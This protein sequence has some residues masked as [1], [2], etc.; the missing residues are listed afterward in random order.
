MPHDQN[1]ESGWREDKLQ[2]STVLEQLKVDKLNVLP[3]LHWF[4]N[5][6]KIQVIYS[7]TEILRWPWIKYFCKWEKALWRWQSKVAGAVC[8]GRFGYRIFAYLSPDQKI[9]LCRYFGTEGI[10]ILPHHTPTIFCTGVF[11]VGLHQL[12]R[13][14]IELGVRFVMLVGYGMKKFTIS[15]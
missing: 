8:I 10:T 5:V 4:S 12:A 14:F 11:L 3:C 6:G 9:E 1:R 13:G 2:N 7:K 15:I